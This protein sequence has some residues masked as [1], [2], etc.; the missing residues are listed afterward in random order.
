MALY[1]GGFN[2]RIAKS[3]L[4]RTAVHSPGLPVLAQVRG[5]SPFFFISPTINHNLSQLTRC[6]VRPFTVLYYCIIYHALERIKI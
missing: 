4:F 1:E 5:I 6:C 3:L 2:A